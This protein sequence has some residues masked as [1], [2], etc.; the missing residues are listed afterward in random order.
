MMPPAAER[1]ARRW[2]LAYAVG[3]VVAGAVLGLMVWQVVVRGPFLAF[4]WRVHE[5]FADRQPG[6]GVRTLL[7]SVAKLGQRWL[8]LPVLLAAG[9]W[10]SWRQ[11]RGRPLLAVLVGLGSAFVVGSVIK[12]GLS[13]TPPYRNIDILHGV[14]EAFPSGHAANATFTWVLVA[15]LLFGARGLRPD[16]RLLRAGLLF[17]AFAALVVGTIMVGLEYHWVS[18]IPGGWTVG[19]LALMLALLALGPPTRSAE[20]DSG[21][22]RSQ[23]L[24]PP[25]E[26]EP[27]SGRGADGDRRAGRLGEDGLGLGAP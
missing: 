17:G 13:R 6:S 8:T 10:V 9:A 5:F 19:L 15:V 26:A 25:G 20:D 22:D 24:T 18:D 7:D 16:P 12:D 3:V 27:V 14:G 2:W 21:G 4:D 23:A 1:P 11:R